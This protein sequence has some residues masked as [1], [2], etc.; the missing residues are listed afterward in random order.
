[1]DWLAGVSQLSSSPAAHASSPE[2]LPVYTLRTV[3]VMEPAPV[4]PQVDATIRPPVPVMTYQRSGLVPALPSHV[5]R[6]AVGEA[7]TVEPDTTL[8]QLTGDA[9][10]QVSLGGGGGPSSRQ[11]VSLPLVMAVS[12]KTSRR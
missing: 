5:G 10:A 3:S 7:V 2:Q 12:S 4:N 11:I 1:M 6:P 8:P 9:V